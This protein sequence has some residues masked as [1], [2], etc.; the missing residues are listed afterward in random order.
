MST[1]VT[2]SESGIDVALRKGFHKMIAYDMARECRA[3]LDARPTCEFDGLEAGQELLLQAVLRHARACSS[4]ANDPE[5]AASRRQRQPRGTAAHLQ[6]RLLRQLYRVRRRSAGA[7]RN[8]SRNG[9]QGR[10]RCRP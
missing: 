2:T 5:A 4:R 8:H 6:G 3:M 1:A 10:R 9:C 7:D